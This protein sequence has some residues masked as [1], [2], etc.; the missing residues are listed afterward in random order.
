MPEEVQPST[1]MLKAQ[2]LS[3]LRRRARE[4]PDRYTDLQR[5]ALDVLHS[6]MQQGPPIPPPA[7]L[8]EKTVGDAFKIG[9]LNLRNMAA[10][11]MDALGYLASLTPETP[12]GMSMGG[13]LSTQYQ[14]TPTIE[15]TKQVEKMNAALDL[16]TS[17]TDKIREDVGEDYVAL[18]IKPEQYSFAKGFTPKAMAITIAEQGPQMLAYMASSALNPVVG[19]LAMAATETGSSMSAIRDYEK[20]SGKKVSDDVKLAIPL[21]AGA[22][23]AALEYTGVSTILGKGPIARLATGKVAKAILAG[24]TE[25]GEEVS[26]GLLDELSQ[27]G[28][29]DIDP[30]MAKR[31][32]QQGQSALIMGLAAGSSVQGV[33]ALGERAAARYADAA[34][35]FDQKEFKTG[36]LN[37]SLNFSDD[38]AVQDA[39]KS[40]VKD[41]KTNK[42]KVSN[43]E[44]IHRVLTIIYEKSKAQDGTSPADP[45]VMQHRAKQMYDDMVI[46]TIVQT[47]VY[48]GKADKPAHYSALIEKFKAA[49]AA[50]RIQIVKNIISSKDTSLLD[51]TL[52]DEFNKIDNQYT[53]DLQASVRSQGADNTSIFT[54]EEYA[55]EHTLKYRSPK[56][57]AIRVEKTKSTKSY[58]DIKNIPADETITIYRALPEGKKITAGDFVSPIKEIVRSY[59]LDIVRKTGQPVK[60]V[61]KKVKAIE[62]KLHPEHQAQGVDDEFIYNP[63]GTQPSAKPLVDKSST[64]TSLDAAATAILNNFAEHS[65]TIEFL[66]NLST[67]PAKL[68]R[69]KPDELKA[70][71]EI[72]L[73]MA[74]NWALWNG[75]HRDD[76][77]A[78]HMWREGIRVGTEEEEQRVIEN[79]INDTTDVRVKAAQSKKNKKLKPSDFT[80]GGIQVWEGGIDGGKS[81]ILAFKSATVE[82]IIHEFTHVMRPLL[83]QEMQD[84]IRKWA[85]TNVDNPTG[86]F[87]SKT[88][89]SFNADEK[90]TGAFIEY[91]RTYKV[92]NRKLEH[93][94]SL[95]KTALIKLWKEGRGYYATPTSEVARVFDAMLTDVAPTKTAIINKPVTPASKLLPAPPNA[96]RVS[97]PVTNRVIDEAEGGIPDAANDGTINYF[98]NP[99]LA[100]TADVMLKVI[101][102]V[103]SAF[104]VVA[105]FKGVGAEKTGIEVQ[106]LL[107]RMEVSDEKALE[108]V[109]HLAKMGMTDEDARD[110]YF[111][112]MDSEYANTLSA[113]R[114]T[115]LQPF[116]DYV[117]NIFD[118]ELPKLVDEG[119]LKQEWPRS[120]IDRETKDM[121]D[122][123]KKVDSI[124]TDIDT[125]SK[126]TVDEALKSKYARDLSI[127]SRIRGTDTIADLLQRNRD[128]LI[129]EWEDRIAVLNDE[130]DAHQQRIDA[131][132]G[133]KYVHLPIR[134]WLQSKYE[135]SKEGFDALLKGTFA[136]IKGRKTADPYTLVQAGLLDIDLV[137][138]RDAVALYVRYVETQRAHKLIR[139]TSV[140][141]GMAVPN[142]YLEDFKVAAKLGDATA[143][144]ELDKFKDYISLPADRYPSY[145]GYKVHPVFADILDDHMGSI[146]GGT[147]KWY[148]KAMIT[149]KLYS[150]W[151]FLVMPA[152]DIYQSAALTQGMSILNIP[153]FIKAV[154]HVKNKTDLYYKLADAGTFS[155]PHAETFSQFKERLAKSKDAQTLL[156]SLKGEYDLLL[157]NWK[158]RHPAGKVLGLGWDIIAEI[159]KASFHLAWSGDKIM[160]TATA[161]TMIDRGYAIEEAGKLTADAH[162]DYSGIPPKTRR[163]LN[164]A[165][166]TPTFQLSMVKWH[167]K[168]LMSPIKLTKSMLQGKGIDK[169]ELARVMTLA[170]TISYIIASDYIMTALLGWDR[171]QFGRKYTKEITTREG[172]RRQ[173][174]TVF[175]NPLNVFIKHYYTFLQNRTDMSK[176]QQVWKY[177]RFYLHP[178]WTDLISLI[179]NKD[180]NGKPIIDPLAD[181]I[182]VTLAK[183]VR[184]EFFRTFQLLSQFAAEPGS[185]TTAWKDLWNS[186]KNAFNIILGA[187]NFFYTRQPNDDRQ[188]A[189]ARSALA[190]LNKSL[191]DNPPTS[192]RDYERRVNRTLKVIDGAA[193]K[194]DGEINNAIINSL[195][196]QARNARMNVEVTETEE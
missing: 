182:P 102:K 126:M 113:E 132:T 53:T 69:I 14:T 148:Q 106:R 71:S 85:E 107:S 131:L 65:K 195:T 9:L 34:K 59:A 160:R 38:P 181:S 82:T 51:K 156:T 196:T 149:R 101:K 43:Q 60:I 56:I 116:V 16:T 37:K 1:N 7:E 174:V 6:R 147:V 64:F 194:L 118:V 161:L 129:K 105:P 77:F 144:A 187:F 20:R 150:F 55:A 96:D 111:V 25:S 22:A 50:T 140:S 135:S 177:G 128:K 68:T 189:I 173:I 2:A 49:D 193:K 74:D 186:D 112:A 93:I 115:Y 10:D 165:L 3:E 5:S 190:R 19:V 154:Y 172:I 42:E 125:L 123:I 24:V 58:A 8:H 180:N 157:S 36:N 39:V 29:K 66:T 90:F 28:Y 159:Y 94:F 35:P 121:D 175:A 45:L 110:T 192:L 72:L 155:T 40:V 97:S 44:F 134:F 158:S 98:V 151:N 21:V 78:D 31:L 18:H 95:L 152:Y 138:V 117:R 188:T 89:W 162:A 109:K 99:K 84:L 41:I 171:D 88:Q 176:I 47:E 79:T 108:K 76:F 133:L 91:L 139:D 86:K 46:P 170:S 83:P 30:G 114:L 100:K 143:Q 80:I 184:Y 146:H 127:G 81:L 183:Y 153:R 12:T 166:F 23:K 136:S 87:D 119:V 70:V 142:K 26:Q 73:Q 92:P 17:V 168:N 33:K 191:K 178:V 48:P 122:K 185:T 169:M 179:D 103:Y 63:E 137:D 13:G 32:L 57:N 15:H 11:A 62:V 130:I 67:L 104:S 27:L 141:E 61:S 54:Q 75:K 52:I 120:A 124:Q 145:V 163:A 164:W 4:T 167:A